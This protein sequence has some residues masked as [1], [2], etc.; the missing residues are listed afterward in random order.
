MRDEA[1]LGFA[2]VLFAFRLANPLAQPSLL[3]QT[4]FSHAL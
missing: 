4:G 2:K 3:G 1:T